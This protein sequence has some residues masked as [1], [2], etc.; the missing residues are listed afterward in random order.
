MSVTGGRAQERAEKSASR[1]DSLIGCRRSMPRHSSRVGDQHRY[2]APMKPMT[3]E[4]TIA[5][6]VDQVWAIMTDID[7]YAE[8]FAGVDAAVLLTGETSA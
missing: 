6:Q 8:R 3:F 4:R 2:H 1:Y 7:R 5:A